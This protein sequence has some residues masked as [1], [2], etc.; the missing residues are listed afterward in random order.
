MRVGA[1][2]DDL[3]AELVIE[4]Q[5]FLIRQRRV[6]AVDVALDAAAI[7]NERAKH[8]PIQLLNP[9]LQYEDLLH[10]SPIQQTNRIKYP[11]LIRR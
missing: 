7:F 10:T 3:A 1:D 4:P 11:L 2:G 5:P 9:V 6:A 8:L